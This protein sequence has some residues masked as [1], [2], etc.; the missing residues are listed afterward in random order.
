M[1]HSRILAEF[2]E[3]LSEHKEDYVMQYFLSMD[4]RSLAYGFTASR[5]TEI[6]SMWLSSVIEDI[7]GGRLSRDGESLRKSYW[8]FVKE[9]GIV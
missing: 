3:Y 5:Y 9:Y 8:E 4:I 2:E 1:D 7:L 6:A